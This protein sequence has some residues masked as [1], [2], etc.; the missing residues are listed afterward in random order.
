MYMFKTFPCMFSA[1][2]VYV[3]CTN[4]SQVHAQGH[5]ENKVYIH[6]LHYTSYTGVICTYM[7]MVYT[8]YNNTLCVKKCSTNSKGC[9]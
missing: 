5:F 8:D 6:V 9:K 1:Q 2:C 3:H 7:N 4:L